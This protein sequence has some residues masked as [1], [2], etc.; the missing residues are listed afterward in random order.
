MPRGRPRKAP[1]ASEL[2]G[3]RVKRVPLVEIYAPEGAPYVPDHLNEDAALCAEQI[4]AA[5][6]KS[7]SLRN[8]DSYV[9]SVFAQAWA[10]HKAAV[11]E[12]SRPGF[13]PIVE[14]DKGVKKPNPW[15]QIMREQALL[16]LA[17]SPKLYLT[18]ADRMTLNVARQ[19]KEKSKFD[20]LIGG[21]LK[22]KID[23][24]KRIN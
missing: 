12:M 21:R 18:P 9:L 17:C 8:I 15:F 1:G 19:G 23:G 24:D 14:S 10:W 6:E 22:E 13:E 3:T 7:N 20:G 5:F 16:M 2:D 4:I 11:E